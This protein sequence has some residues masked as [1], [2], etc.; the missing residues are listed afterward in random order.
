MIRVVPLSLAAIALG[1]AALS[2]A[3]AQAQRYIGEVVSNGYSFCP[4]GTAPADGQLLSISNNDALFSLIGTTYGGDG[5][6]TF[7]LP[8]LRGR[9]PLHSGTGPGLA[10]VGWGQSG[11]VQQITLSEANLANHSHTVNA[12]N[13]DG[14]RPGPGDKL[15]AAAPPSGTGSETIYSDQAPTVTMSPLMIAPVGGGQPVAVEDPNTV[16]NFCVVTEG[17]YPPRS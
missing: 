11:G 6:T 1:A 15:L 4:L 17:I 16:V 2:P 13:L 12:N 3:P 10:P 14:D 5:I 8:D 9:A 7:G